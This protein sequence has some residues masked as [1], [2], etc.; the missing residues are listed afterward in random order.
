MGKHNFWTASA[1][2]SNNRSL[3]AKSARYRQLL[4]LKRW[5]AAC[6]ETQFLTTPLSVIHRVVQTGVDGNHQK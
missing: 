5:W 3:P 6:P 2:L 4:H 1:D